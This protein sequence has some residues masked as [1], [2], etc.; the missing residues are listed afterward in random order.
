MCTWFATICFLHHKLR[1]KPASLSLRPIGDGAYILSGPKP[2]SSAW[3]L[4]LRPL[5]LIHEGRS[6]LAL[7]L[8]GL[9]NSSPANSVASQA[10]C[11]LMV[12]LTVQVRKFVRS[13]DGGQ[14]GRL[15]HLLVCSPPSIGP[16]EIDASAAVRLSS[17]LW[18]CH[19]DAFH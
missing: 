18:S 5:C 16:C 2:P 7:Y 15:C 12:P 14:G 11:L 6:P 10:R 4:A 17:E 3:S 9:Y 1:G 8:L 13:E 19:S